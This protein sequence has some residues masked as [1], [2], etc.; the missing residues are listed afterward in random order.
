MQYLAFKVKKYKKMSHGIKYLAVFFTILSFLSVSYD[1]FADEFHFENHFVGDRA[2]TLA[3]AYTALSDD[4]AGLYYNPAGIVFGEEGASASLNA[5]AG[6]NTRYN[7]VLGDIDWNRKSG[8]LVPGLL[9]GIYDVSEGKAK[10]G[11]SLIVTDSELVEQDE[12]L[13][14]IKWDGDIWFHEASLHYKNEYRIYNVG[15]SYAFKTS[16]HLS[17]GVTLYGYWKKKKESL[18]QKFIYDDP[19]LYEYDYTSVFIDEKELGFRPILG[20]MW[21]PDNDFSLGISV[22]HIYLIS[23][24]YSYEYTNNYTDRARGCCI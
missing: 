2:G 6:S 24:D 9:G 19:T 16:D 15:P 18:S 17:F 22:S 4:P 20:L 13:E 23:R 21:K 8:E 5:Y 14:N 3:G 1:S 7:K 10:F 12:R 11:F